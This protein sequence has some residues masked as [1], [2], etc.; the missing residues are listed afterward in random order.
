MKLSSERL[1]NRVDP[2]PGEHLPRPARAG[3]VGLVVLVLLLVVAFGGWRPWAGGGRT[4]RADFANADQMVLGRTPV[5]IAGVKVGTVS[6]V[7]RGSNGRG[8]IVVM[9]ITDDDVQ[10]KRDASAHIRLRTV[11]AGTRYIDLDPG[12][13]S[14]GPLGGATI[15]A[16]NTSSQVDW[17]DLNQILEPN[18]RHGQQ[19]VLW[20]LRQGLADP[21]AT[22]RTIDT[23]GPSL[24]TVGRGLEALRGDH[25]G[26]LHRLVV[27]TGS[28]LDA[29]SRDRVALTSLVREGAHTLGVTDTHRVA[30]GQ[31][32]ALSPAALGSTAV[33]MRRLDRT[34]D[35]LD[36]LVVDL[37]P[38]VRRLAPAAQALRPALDE[39]DRLLRA[40]GPILRDLPPALRNL[41]ATSRQAVPLM[42]ALDPTVRRLRDELLP[43]LAK[44]DEDTELATYEAIG[45]AFSVLDSAAADFDKNGWFFHFPITPSGDTVLLKCGAGLTPGELQRCDAV[46]GVLG[47]AL[48][49]TKG[50]H[51]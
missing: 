1:R 36:P 25:N 30:L 26:D 37:R 21:A 31:A 7:E 19:Q 46:N 12:S 11:L 10:L 15:T 33:T 43:W 3:V 29:V 2:V 40:T 38:G 39:A 42:R 4:L 18:V 50:R 5:R 41:A 23:L 6:R 27:S 32:I 8:A 13:P 45:P 9:R 20:G 48:G 49:S 28:V 35:H 14:A 16:P 51:R 24:T 47:K 17:D 34:L 44:E 22:A